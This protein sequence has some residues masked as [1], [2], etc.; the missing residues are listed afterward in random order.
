MTDR[1]TAATITDEQLDALYRRIETLEHVAA[2][3]KRHVQLIVP[4]IDRLTAELEDAEQRADGFRREW[5][6]ARDLLAAVL[7]AFPDTGPA[8]RSRPLPAEL[9]HRWRQTAGAG[10]PRVCS[11]HQQAATE[12][13]EPDTEDEDEETGP[14]VPPALMDAIDR[15]NEEHEKT[16]RALAAHT[17]ELAQ[18][19]GPECA[20]G[21][22]YTGRCEG[23]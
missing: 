3:N 10:G 8:I 11:C 13:T 1:P 14:L 16:A 9:V 6:Q 21:H 17:A 15:A 23:A 2:G 22:T 19:C 5:D 20:E 7:A 4:E 12:A 18:R